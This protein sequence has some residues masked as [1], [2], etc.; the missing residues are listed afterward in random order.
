MFNHVYS[1]Q[2]RTATGVTYCRATLLQ[3]KGSEQTHINMYVSY[4][5]E[6]VKQGRRWRFQKREFEILC[7]TEPV[8]TRHWAADEGEIAARVHKSGPYVPESYGSLSHPL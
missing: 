7:F 2:D 8:P 3:G 6:L 4:R 1:I 5:Y